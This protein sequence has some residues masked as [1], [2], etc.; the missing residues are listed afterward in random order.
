MLYLS[1]PQGYCTAAMI[2]PNL[3]VTARHCVAQ[4]TLGTFACTPQ[5]DL[6]QNSTGAGSQGPDYM[7]NQLGFYTAEHVAENGLA[8]Y[9]TTPDALGSQIFDTQTLTSCRDDVAFV[10]L[11][12]P[13]PGR[14]PLPVRLTNNTVVGEEVGV[15]GYGL[16]EVQTDPRALRSRGN[17]AIEGVGPDV[18]VNEAEAAPLRAV[19][20]GPT[21]ATCNGDSGAPITAASTGAII[22]IVSLGYEAASGTLT[23]SDSMTSATTGPRLAESE[24]VTIA[25]MA[26][27]AA[28]Q[29]PILE[30]VGAEPVLVADAAG[31]NISADDAAESSADAA[32]VLLQTEAGCSVGMRARSAGLPP[33]L[34]LLVVLAS[35]LARRRSGSRRHK[36]ALETT[37]RGGSR[38]NI[39]S[40]YCACSCASEGA[41][42]EFRPISRRNGST[43]MQQG[44]KVKLVRP[45][46]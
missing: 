45:L 3:V 11:N 37:A 35:A 6:V 36:V 44:E 28:G 7:P 25:M 30:P 9:M 33:V 41:N 1:G 13:L 8:V 32:G 24:Y 12:Q 14:T 23:C 42:I 27:Q 10:V 31:Q 46:L 34:S 26:F 20:I 40:A 2:A 19:R 22:G 18:P 15:T 4:I 21:A 38:D 17:L 43:H 39:P 16:T 29:T 5:G